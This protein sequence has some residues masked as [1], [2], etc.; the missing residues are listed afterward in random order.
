M[1]TR[2]FVLETPRIE[3]LV[4]AERFYVCS[5]G[6]RVSV[7]VNL[8]AK[9][10][11]CSTDLSG[12]SL[13]VT[14]LS[15]AGTPAIN[16]TQNTVVSAV[17]KSQDVRQ[18]YSLAPGRY[19]VAAVAGT[20]NYRCGAED[21]FEVVSLGVQA[22][23]TTARTACKEVIATAQV[24]GA[25]DGNLSYRWYQRDA[26][27]AFTPY[28]SAAQPHTDATVALPPGTYQLRVQIGQAACEVSTEFTV[29]EP[30]P[31]GPV[32]FTGPV[33]C[34]ITAQTIVPEAD[35]YRVEWYVKPSAQTPD[36]E[37]KLVYSEYVDVAAANGELKSN[38]PDQHQSAGTAYY[39]VRIYDQWGCETISE[40]KPLNKP[41]VNRQYVMCLQW[42]V[43]PPT[44]TY[45]PPVPVQQPAAL[46]ASDTRQQ[47]DEA[48]GN[49]KEAQRQE[50]QA[51]ASP[52]LCLAN[53]NDAIQL[54]YLQQYH[55]YT[56]YY[57]DRAGNLTKTVPPAGVVP[58]S[59]SGLIRNAHP[60]AR[61]KHTLATTYR[62]NGLGQLTQQFTPDGGT[63]HFVY[64]G[65]GQLRLS[66]NDR[67][68]Q[69]ESG[70]FSYTKYDELGRVV[71]VGQATVP[72][73]P[74]NDAHRP[75]F[76]GFIVPANDALLAGDAERTRT[77]AGRYPAAAQATSSEQTV[78][79]YSE[80]SPGLTYPNTAQEPQTFLRNRVSRTFT[81][82]RADNSRITTHYSYDPHGNVRWLTQEM[83]VAGRSFV[84]YSYDLISGKVLQVAYN[85]HRP[86]RFFHRYAYD[87]DNRLQ[88]V[89]TSRDGLL[90]DRDATYRYYAHGPLRRLELGQDNVQ[91]MDYTYTLHGWL[92]G[93]NAPS[94]KATENER[95]AEDPGQDSYR[96]PNGT[97]SPFSRDEFAM[98]LGYYHGDYLYQGS[99]FDG[100]SAQYSGL[101]QA[102]YRNLYNGNISTWLNQSARIGTTT[103]LVTE[104]HAFRYDRL[105]RLRESRRSLYSGS[106]WTS[107]TALSTAYTYDGNG[108][109]ETLQ[110]RDQNGNPLDDLRYTYPK[111]DAGR[112]TANRLS[113]VTD[114]VGSTEPADD[115]EGTTSYTY[116]PI[117]NLS[118][119]SREG[120]QVNWNVYGKVSSVQPIPGNAAGANKPTL[121]YRYDAAGNRVAKLVTPPNGTETATYYVR[122]AQGNI[123]ATYEKQGETSDAPLR[124]LEQ[125]LYGSDRIG[126]RDQVVTLESTAGHL[127]RNGYTYRWTKLSGPEVTLQTPNDPELKLADL[128]PGSYLFR[129]TAT[130]PLGNTGSDEVALQVPAPQYPGNGTIQSE[131]W[132]NLAGTSISQIPTG[133]PPTYPETSNAFEILGNGRTNYGSRMRGY[134]H[135]PVSGQYQ[136]L[137]ASGDPSELWLSP[138][139]DPSLKRLIANV[140]SSSAVRNYSGPT[141][142]SVYIQLEAGQRYYIEALYKEGNATNGEHLSVAWRM[143]DNTTQA[144]ITGTDPNNSSR[145]YLSAF[146]PASGPA[147]G[148]N[149][150]PTARLQLAQS[151][152]SFPQGTLLQLNAAVSDP[153]GTI[154]RVEF[155]NGATKI[156]EDL[157]APF[158]FAWV[159]NAGTYSLTAKAFD[160]AGAST[161][162][163][164]V[165]VT[166]Q[167]TVLRS[168]TKGINLNGV[169]VSGAG[170]TI[171]DGKTWEKPTYTGSVPTY[172]SL[173]FTNPNILHTTPK[174]NLLTAT[175]AA[176]ATMLSTA[177]TSRDIQAT[178]TGL[179]NARYDVYY[180]VLED[181]KAETINIDV[182]NILV[183][184]QLSTGPGG[185]WQRLGPF[186]TTVSNSTTT[187]GNGTI[188]IRLRIPGTGASINLSGIEVWKVEEAGDLRNLPSPLA[189]GSITQELWT[190]NTST[191]FPANWPPPAATP[192]MRASTRPTTRAPTTGSG[193]GATCALDFSIKQ[194]RQAPVEK[195]GVVVW[196]FLSC[197]LQQQTLKN[198]CQSI[199]GFLLR[200][201]HRKRW[202]AACHTRLSYLL[203][204][205]PSSVI[206][207][208]ARPPVK[209]RP[210]TLG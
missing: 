61:P 159:P 83:P 111:D 129:L 153:D 21:F 11:D 82:N 126:Q 108:N 79:V 40:F 94:L 163:A 88:T 9:V 29:A 134:V 48:L 3:D 171:I 98:S 102:S 33:N 65:L 7:P 174:V 149:Q 72:A 172:A 43:V 52:E 64:N 24:T 70:A 57:F 81:T 97:S 142:G 106:A 143:P 150:P 22:T 109:L 26:S 114:L 158:A 144:V 206:G 53:V 17:G 169:A 125:P 45:T 175:D 74:A 67:Q 185:N 100:R 35:R 104:A 151:G 184:T 92:K 197:R 147:G 41:H 133:T 34:L 16:P 19:R 68:R 89:E 194:P 155:F 47:L 13:A 73:G 107:S 205:F 96:N 189:A 116:D 20:N 15:E 87:E 176:R 54:T 198:Y 80:A 121:R 59:G 154:S 91:G 6:G 157:I 191:T 46:F 14:A 204:A 152:S 203:A 207:Q 49:C 90:W 136:F 78:T 25:P 178:I 32:T 208:L 42:Q 160:N 51:L 202:A 162:S 8:L 63:T 56:L 165:P 71:E 77:P 118:Q 135:P 75:A 76:N 31:L 99:L 124:L 84:R 200:Q 166:I 145:Y 2:D 55:H 131:Y 103:G 39:A 62:Y 196:A 161:E 180:Y 173:T 140:P 4:S 164:P 130:D 148:T 37:A 58:L 137:I 23:V 139:D 28:P 170:A 128:K 69:Q 86:D 209:T 167:A 95:A 119:D 120:I 101:P 44:Y 110:R 18:Q 122:D 113:G 36:G 210:A 195:A 123:L 10:A 168:F 186:R 66:Q 193:C 30:K 179:A 115:L 187:A 105:N 192:S 117:G 60:D 201:L 50:V 190:N 38:L 146:I 93:I 188:P 132:A 112:I 156:G 182:N 127:Y 138:S 177:V 141:Q 12:Y 27:N 1:Y 5:P 85:E 183:V 199:T 181:N